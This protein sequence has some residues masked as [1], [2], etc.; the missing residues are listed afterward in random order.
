MAGSFGIGLGSFLKGVADGANA[1]S[2]IQTAK[3][4]QKL[5]DMRVKEA[6]SNLAEKTAAQDRQAEANAL[7]KIGL[8]N[9][10]NLYGDDV[11]KVMNLEPLRDKIKAFNWELM[12][13]NGHSME[14]ITEVLGKA[15]EIVEKPVFI[16]ADT[17]KGKGVSFMENNPKWHSGVLKE[18]EYITGIKDIDTGGNNNG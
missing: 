5:N 2:G 8:D 6:E 9:A 15:K 11:N 3:S 12:E 10:K 17:V 16:I 7:M 13:I 4:Q 1:Y 18:E 14:E